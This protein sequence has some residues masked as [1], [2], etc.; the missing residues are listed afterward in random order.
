MRIYTKDGD[1]RFVY[2]DVGEG[3]EVVNFMYKNGIMVHKVDGDIMT[4]DT[5]D[6]MSKNVNWLCELVDFYK[7]KKYEVTAEAQ[8]IVDD[9]KQRYEEERIRRVEERIKKNLE[10][11]ENKKREV[12]GVDRPYYKIV[13]RNGSFMYREGII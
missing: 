1:K 4:F 7:R 8:Q 3:N 12:P 2:I 13:V 11:S 10:E 9:I 5:A 6:S